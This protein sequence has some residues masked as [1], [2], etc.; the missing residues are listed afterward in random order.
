MLM[1]FLVRFS[2]ASGTHQYRD[3]ATGR[4]K[5]DRVG[6]RPPVQQGFGAATRGQ[7]FHRRPRGVDEYTAGRGEAEEGGHDE[8]RSRPQH[9]HLLLLH[10]YRGS[11][12]H[13]PRVPQWF[14]K[15]VHWE[16][17]Y[18]AHHLDLVGPCTAYSR[19]HKPAIYKCRSIVRCSPEGT[20][21][22][23]DCNCSLSGRWERIQAMPWKF[24]TR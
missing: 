5:T 12:E 18:S 23:Q 15:Y 24:P 7:Q 16:D 19:I 21:S 13:Q 8:S 11:R 22:S 2:C 3:A 10:V 6:S 17:R 9:R 1:R 14:S 4:C 20:N